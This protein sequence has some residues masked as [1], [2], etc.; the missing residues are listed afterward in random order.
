M[1][2]GSHLSIAGSMV[3]ALLEAESL[4]MTTV[5]VFTKNQQQWKANPLDPGM[6]KDWHAHVSRLGWHGR[7]V[8]HASYL[9]NLASVNDELFAKSIDLM[10]DEIERCETLAIPYLVHHPGSF[11]GWTLEK[12]IA[13]IASAYKELF[14]RTKGA[15][16]IMCL[17]GTAGAGSQIGGPFEHLRDLRAQI[18][19]MS[20]QPQRVGFCLDTCHLHAA[21]HD[22]STRASATKVLARFDE[23]CG[24]NNLH[25]F[26]INDSKGAL[27]T[28]LDRHAHI[29][30]GCV[31]TETL[32]TGKPGSFS[33]QRLTQS[34]F[35]TVMNLPRCKEIPLILETP[36]EEDPKARQTAPDKRLDSMNLRRLTSLLDTPF[37][38]V[39]PAG[40]A[41]PASSKAIRATQNPR[42]AKPK[43]SQRPTAQKSRSSN[44]K[45]RSPRSR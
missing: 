13:R 1:L 36:K 17:E 4:G 9:I 41:V 3:N 20:S 33:A 39:Y 27:G 35:H 25:A 11:T 8:S 22:M 38:L 26:H 2:L 6:V 32:S 23:L 42:L 7:I 15:K 18:V 24:L 44:S 29:G 16:T 30:E 10:T 34:G 43:T 37:E 21:G 45:A 19:D 5:Q 31:G 14:R 40:A 12:G 28:H